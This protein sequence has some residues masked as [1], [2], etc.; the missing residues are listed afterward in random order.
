MLPTASAARPGLAL[1]S[2]TNVGIRG[3]WRGWVT[4]MARGLQLGQVQFYLPYD[5]ARRIVRDK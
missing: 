5:L 3:N 1:H 2:G 4:R